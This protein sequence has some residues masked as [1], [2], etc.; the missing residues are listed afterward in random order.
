MKRLPGYLSLAAPIAALLVAGCGGATRTTQVWTDPR[1]E[2]NS[3][4][5]LMVIGIGTTPTIRRIFEDRFV[6]ALQ[7]QGV[8]AEP[9]YRL[10]GDG[11]LDSARTSAEMHRTGC[12]GVFVTRVVDRKTVRA[13]YPAT[14]LYPAAF[15]GWSPPY[16][17]GWPGYDDWYGYYRLGY[18]YATA[19]GYTLD[20]QVISFETTLY[21]VADG[22]LVWS[23]L[24]EEWREQ[25][26]LQGDE[27][28][29]LVR[30]LVGA[31]LNSK[32]VTARGE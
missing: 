14:P 32:V 13:Y 19:P 20:N 24:S 23:A 26:D 3:L 25:S 4:R 11:N 16:R 2:P 6:A 17:H 28:D 31:L 29:P 27:V 18:A 9:S 7:A 15:Y 5:K 8:S 22:A 10:V 1:V 30:Q 21:R 12:D